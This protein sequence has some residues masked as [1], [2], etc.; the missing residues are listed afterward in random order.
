MSK[1]TLPTVTNGQ[2]IS[3]INSNF[4]AIQD[5]LNNNV[6]YRDNPSG[7]PNQM[8]QD[9]DMNGK[10]L[11]NIGSISAQT[12]SLADGADL[13]TV[14]AQMESDTSTALSN[15]TDAKADA[16]SAL[17]QSGSALSTANGL[18]SQIQTAVTQSAQAETDASTALSTANGIDAK[19]TSALSQ[20]GTALTN[21]NAAVTTANGIASTANTAL[22]QSATAVS[23]ANSAAQQTDENL[24]HNPRFRICQAAFGLNGV[25]TG[26]ANTQLMDRWFTG[27][28]G[29]TVSWTVQ[30]SSAKS[31]FF[32]GTRLGSRGGVTISA[33]SIAQ[34][35]YNPP[36]GSFVLTWTGTATGRV[37]TNGGARPSYGAS[38]ISV[39]FDGASDYGIEFTGGTLDNVRIAQPHTVGQA[40]P[41]RNDVAEF[42]ICLGYFEVVGSQSA[43][44]G[45]VEIGW[46]VCTA[47][48]TLSGKFNCVYKFGP[49]QT[50][51]YNG[52]SAFWRGLAA[53]VPNLTI[54]AMSMEN[55]VTV[56]WTATASSASVGQVF[57][58]QAQDGQVPA[59]WIRADIAPS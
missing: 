6:L 24:V 30:A 22:S 17:S 53:N 47:T 34:R 20:S 11:L 12:I 42:N 37:F 1:I 23:T 35:L 26:V 45:R 44:D 51:T 2:N 10:S 32:M 29:T 49:V 43:E 40:F 14:V 15:S 9:L 31:G 36:A 58:A 4:S 28:I 46:G 21:A 38:G 33:G 25:A 59:V 55:P 8:M 48:N 41:N 56:S 50:I 57:L 13:N 54:T 39:T 52:G 27:A 5:A 7:E 19:A 3:T 16:A 18:N